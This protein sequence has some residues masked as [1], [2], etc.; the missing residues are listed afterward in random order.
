[1]RKDDARRLDHATL[2]AMRERAVRSVQDGES[3]EVVAGVLGIN[4]STMYGWLAQY[5]R[6]GWGALK[7]KPLFGR[8]PKL[9]GKKLKWI[10]D[11][12]TQKNPLQLKF[13]FA[14]WTREMVATLIKDKFDI[15]LSLVSRSTRRHLPEAAASCV[16]T[17]R[18]S[19]A[20]VA[21]AGIP[22]DQS[23]GAAGKG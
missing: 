13:A 20:A 10:Y 9:D 11:T 22:E 5:R 21:Q 6:G 3:P 4:R 14:L 18:S 2:E 1:M 16:G 8:P 19:G 17:G 15:S 12:V 23:S 7:A